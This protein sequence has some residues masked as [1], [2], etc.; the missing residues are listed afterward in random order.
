MQSRQMRL[1]SGAVLS[2]AAHLAPLLGDDIAAVLSDDRVVYVRIGVEE[3]KK[4]EM[5]ELAGET[6]RS[7]G[8][9]FV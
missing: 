9:E 6:N 7:K 1:G 8:D 4:A 5:S 2:Q 3:L